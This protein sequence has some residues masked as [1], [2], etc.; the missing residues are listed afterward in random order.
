MKKFLIIMLLSCLGGTA[1]AQGQIFDKYE[2]QK[3]VET[4]YVSKSMLGLI[5]KLADGGAVKDKKYGEIAKYGKRLDLVR[6]LACEQSA[7]AKKIYVDV[8]NLLKDKSFETLVREKSDGEETLICLRE[9]GGKSHYLVCDY[10][11]QE[12]N[13]VY[14]VGDL[15]LEDIS[16]I[17]ASGMK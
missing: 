15:K 1:M 7:L 17:A 6:T 9:D 14:I 8:S 5:S 16:A 11:G 2:D 12:I 13:L 3:G 4:V 10:D